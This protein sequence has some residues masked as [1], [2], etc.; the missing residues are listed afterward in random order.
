MKQTSK[1]RMTLQA[2]GIIVAGILM[3]TLMAL[4]LIVKT[5]IGR[6]WLSWT[7][8]QEHSANLDLKE[9]SDIAEATQNLA[10]AGNKFGFD[11]YAKLR[12]ESSNENI[13]FSPYSLSTAFG[14]LYEG[15]SGETA[16][17][18]AKVFGNAQDDALRHQAARQQFA[19]YSNDGSFKV[20]NSLWLQDNSP[21]KP[22][23]V[24]T[25]NQVFGGKAERVDFAQA[26]TAKTINQWVSDQT[27]QKINDLIG[28]L[29]PETKL[30]LANAVY[31]KADWQSKFAADQTKEQ[32]FTKEDGQKIKTKLMN[33][34]GDFAYMEN[35]LLQ[36]VKMPYADSGFEMAV[37]L[38]KNKNLAGLE[39]K[40]TR[41]N[42]EAWLKEAS[43]E[44]VELTLPRFKFAQRLDKLVPQLKELGVVKAFGGKKADF[45]KLTDEPGLELDKVEH[46]AFID[47]Y[48]EG[49]GAAAATAMTLNLGGAIADE[50]LE[51]KIF[52]A[53]H[54][55]VF[56]IL[57]QETQQVIF[58]GKL[59]DPT[60]E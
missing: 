49:S 52:R 27:N 32:D 57:D 8:P 41:E 44:R 33:Q 18:L 9:P 16:T 14:M 13:F 48:E 29:S 58:L 26:E 40:L 38:P 25:V 1:K 23:F 17:E 42:V 28:D 55:F 10:L 15:A 37:L 56:M 36:L 39:N 21:I 31:F 53:D 11:L 12:Q 60:K 59:V 5:P 46:M 22:E 45:S 19:K 43:S 7:N 35:N 34:T 3:I 4:W 50:K 47:V 20:A 2:A 6:N 54:P 30:V 51:V 24:Q